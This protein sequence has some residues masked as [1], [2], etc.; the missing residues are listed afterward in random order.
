MK[1]SALYKKTQAI[2]ERLNKRMILI[3]A[4]PGVGKT[5]M[6]KRINSFKP[7]ERTAVDLDYKGPKAVSTAIRQC[8]SRL[9]NLWSKEGVKVLTTFYTWI[10]FNSLD[11]ENVAVF[12]IDLAE[13]NLPE[14][15]ARIKERSGE[16]K[17]FYY[18]ARRDY[19]QWLADMHRFVD[20][21]PIVR[22][23]CTVVD[24][25]VGKGLSDWLIDF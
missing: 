6:V 19:K 11:Y 22:K 24:M 12:I 16:D 10:D 8:H 18:E 9:I 15:L 1:D 21:H 2:C 23:K 3:C 5:T 20:E 25:P 4:M 17:T 7:D 14:I 13:A